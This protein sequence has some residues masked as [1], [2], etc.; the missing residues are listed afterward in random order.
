MA[1]ESLSEEEKALRSVRWGFDSLGRPC[2]GFKGA[3]V[4]KIVDR[5]QAEYL[6]QWRF[7]EE[8]SWVEKET[9]VAMGYESLVRLEDD[10]QA[11]CA[12]S[13]RELTKANVQKHLSCFQVEASESQMPMGRLACPKLLKIL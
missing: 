4:E 3:V 13:A 5:R 1:S 2:K 11:S 8:R 7:K 6:V 10:W 12:F 9:L